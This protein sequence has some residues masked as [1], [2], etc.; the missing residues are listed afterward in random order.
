MAYGDTCG[1]FKLCLPHVGIN[2]SGEFL[3]CCDCA[4][5]EVLTCNE[6]AQWFVDVKGSP[7]VCTLDGTMTVRCFVDQRDQI[8]L[9]F[10]PADVQGMLDSLTLA[11]ASTSTNSS[12]WSYPSQNQFPPDV[13]D[14]TLPG[15]LSLYPYAVMPSTY[16]EI[17]NSGFGHYLSAVMGIRRVYAACGTGRSIDCQLQLKAY[18]RSRYTTPMGGSPDFTKFTGEMNEQ[19]NSDAFVVWDGIGTILPEWIPEESCPEAFPSY[20]SAAIKIS[21]YFNIIT[22]TGCTFTR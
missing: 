16:V 10:T 21:S 4:E 22:N 2:A 9:S 5:E 13:W 11:Y 8:D 1:K 19:L 18:C 14:G 6:C 7:P 3:I 17:W 12:V 15:D 20:D